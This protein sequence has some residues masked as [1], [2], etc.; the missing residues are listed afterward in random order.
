MSADKP[1]LWHLGIS[2]YS[3]KVRWALAYKGIEHERR[4]PP[5]PGVHMLQALWLTRG[6]QATFPVFRIDDRTIGDST[7]IIA[8]LDE[9]HPD[10]PLYP[11]DPADRGRALALEEWFDE[12]LGPQIRRF[13]WHEAI[14]DQRMMAE[15]TAANMPAALRGFGLARSGARRFASTFVGVRFRA[16]SDEGAE[17]AR[18][19]VLAALDR[20]EDEL[21]EGEYLVGDRFTV[22]DLTAAALFYP[23]VT[24]PEGPRLPEPPSQLEEFRE[25]LKER[26]GYRWVAEMFR[27]HRKPATTSPR[28][29]ARP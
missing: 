23:L 15:L 20:L 22:A 27:R 19:R 5:A 17:A 2:H 13:A 29:P 12:E 1:V 3:E 18:S 10:P 28:S 14:K 8:A 16:R 11:A 21:A 7:A 25:P 26:R 6:A 4:P 9:L 24:P